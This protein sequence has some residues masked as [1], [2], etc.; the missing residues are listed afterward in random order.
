[1]FT[2]TRAVA[3]LGL[4]GLCL[5]SP[6]LAQS[7]PD[8]PDNTLDARTDETVFVF[9]GPLTSGYFSDA[10]QPW[11]W[12]FESNVFVGAGY[13]RF[14][15]AYES[16]ALGV[17]AGLGLRLGTPSSAEAWAGLVG[18]LT[19]FELGDFNVTPSVTAGLSVVTDT[20]GAE[21]RRTAQAGESATVLYY[22]APEI[23][24]SHDDH[25]EWEAF[26]RIQH[27]SGGF[28]TI[29]HIDGANAIT[30]GLRYKF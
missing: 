2:F 29:A 9:G 12:D 6:A 14:F 11:N 23:A 13:Q 26:T 21:S 30:A 27:R 10:V 4:A 22:L 1:M 3:A 17:E 16:F 15:Y 8:R 5:M 24:V 7:A 19:E 20:I 25:P 28:G 18:R